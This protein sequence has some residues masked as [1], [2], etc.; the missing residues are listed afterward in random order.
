M[1]THIWA[2]ALL[3]ATLAGC[4]TEPEPLHPVDMTTTDRTEDYYARLRAWKD[5]CLAPNYGGPVAFGWYGNWVGSGV[6]LE[7][8]LRGLPDSVALISMWGNLFNLNEARR[9]D[10]RYAQQVKGLRV[11]MC[12]IVQNVGDG[13]TPPTVSSDPGARTAFW[14]EQAAAK[15]MT[16]DQAGAIRAYA[17]AICDSIDKY[18]YDGFDW[19]YEPHYGHSGNIAGQAAAEKAFAQALDERLHPQGGPRK[20]LV[21]DGEPQSV[22]AE[23]GPLFDYFIVQAYQCTGDYDLDGRYASTRSRHQGSM[24]AAEVAKRYIVTENFETYAL[25][26]GY[27]SYYKRWQGAWRGGGKSMPSL[28]GMAYWKPVVDGDTLQ[29]GGVGTYH[30]EYEYMPGQQPSYPALRQAI[31]IM[32][33]NIDPE[34]YYSNQQQTNNN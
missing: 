14:Q 28:R 20:L 21:I 18:G 11:M 10:M 3:A 16:A 8:S 13:V 31:Q 34:G 9:A 6:S 19:D 22:N 24:K 32:H 12:F 15:G 4:D 26:G 17:H 25:T 23:V 7:N 2:A 5:S 1:R 29:K 30:M 27:T 33:G